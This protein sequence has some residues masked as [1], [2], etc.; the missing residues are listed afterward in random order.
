MGGVN[1]SHDSLRC[2]LSTLLWNFIY[3]N[4]SPPVSATFD[5]QSHAPIPLLDLLPLTFNLGGTVV[6]RTRRNSVRAALMTVFIHHVCC[7][8]TA[9]A[10]VAARCDAADAV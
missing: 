2:R 7:I 8:T 5:L 6:M 9:L 10:N 1:P 4:A 3:A